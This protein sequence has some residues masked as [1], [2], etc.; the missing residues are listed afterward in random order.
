MDIAQLLGIEDRLVYRVQKRSDIVF[1]AIRESEIDIIPSPMSIHLS[2]PPLQSM[3][4]FDVSPLSTVSASSLIIPVPISTTA[5]AHLQRTNAVTTIIA[6][7]AT[8]YSPARLYLQLPQS[9][10]SRVP[11][12]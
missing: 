2:E 4:S 11:M 6:S 1:Q 9:P 10:L 8:S 12:R 5:I 3:P 7:T